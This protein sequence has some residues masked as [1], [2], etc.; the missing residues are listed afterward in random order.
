MNEWRDDDPEM[1]KRRRELRQ[2]ATQAEA[3]LWGAIRKRKVDGLKFR[4]QHPIAGFIADF[5]CVEEKLVIELDGGYHDLCFDRD[6]SR[7]RTMERL[8]WRVVRFANED[9]IDDVDV[10]VRAIKNVIGGR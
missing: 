9:V 5:A 8:G 10:I 2:R 4:R 7:Q 6:Q 3:L 1:L